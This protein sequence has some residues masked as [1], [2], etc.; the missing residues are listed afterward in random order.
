MNGVVACT[1]DA[2]IFSLFRLGKKYMPQ[3]EKSFVVQKRKGSRA[4]FFI[5]NTMS[6]F[7]YVGN[8]IDGTDTQVRMEEATAQ[9]NIHDQVRFPVEKPHPGNGIP[10]LE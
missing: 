1:Y 3:S 7:G 8:G 2:C 4:Y 10:A 9:G 5:L 6:G